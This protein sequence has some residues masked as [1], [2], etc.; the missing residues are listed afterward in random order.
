MVVAVA[1]L[2]SP[3]GLLLLPVL[4]VPA[5]G[6]FRVATR[7]ARG[8]AVS[9]WDAADAWRA[10]LRP[11]L[12]IGAAMV[13]AALI[14]TGNVAIGLG[15]ASPIGW[16]LA[17]LA[18]WGL[19]ALWLFAWTLW[20]ILADPRR[21]GRPTTERVRLAALLLLAHPVRIGALGLTLGVFLVASTVAIVALVTISAALSALIAS[22]FI[23]PA[24]DRLEARLGQP[25]TAPLGIADTP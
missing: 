21:A 5:A 8:D 3:L 6:M 22:Q 15:G 7:I 9:F 2:V 14:L 10:D 4:A 11:T 20:P 24:A 13:A 18:G 12:G 19:I 16:A 17:T 25:I 23:L 1:T